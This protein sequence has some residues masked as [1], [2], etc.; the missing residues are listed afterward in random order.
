MTYNVPEAE[1]AQMPP[2]YIMKLLVTRRAEIER[3]AAS[4]ADEARK[5]VN[6]GRQR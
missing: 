4:V 5:K 6:E 2:H 1:R 3:F